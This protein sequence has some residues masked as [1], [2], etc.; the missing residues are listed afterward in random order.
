MTDMCIIGH[1]IYY[2][3]YVEVTLGKK[4]FVECV[5]FFDTFC[6]EINLL[7]KAYRFY[8]YFTEPNYVLRIN[9]MTKISFRMNCILNI[10]SSFHNENYLIS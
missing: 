5:S 10:W 6:Q 1:I 3:Q 9:E 8:F 2:Q 4:T 7:L